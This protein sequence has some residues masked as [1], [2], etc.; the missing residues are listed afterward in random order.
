MKKTCLIIGN[1]PSLANVPNAFLERFPTFG[2][3]RIYL[4][5]VPEIYACVNPLVTRQY[6]LEI[7]EMKCEKYIDITTADLI[8]GSFK[9]RDLHRAEFS[10]EPGW[11]G[12]GYTVTSVLLQIAYWHGY[13][14]IGLIGVDHRYTFEGKPNQELTAGET[15]PNH[16][17]SSYFTNVQWNAPDLAKSE[18]AYKLARRAF[19]DRGGEIINLSVE[20][21]LDVFERG[22]W[23]EW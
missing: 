2:S 13:K 7:S 14:R 8:P 12:A 6:R 19:E 17:D 20:S 1:G 16:F 23:R 3:N 9:I 21:A 10:T 4:K 22:D 11:Y 5:F 18:L 15:D